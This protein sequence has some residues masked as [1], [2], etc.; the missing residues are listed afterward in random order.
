[1]VGEAQE[2]WG[3]GDQD[4]EE[5]VPEHKGFGGHVNMSRLMKAMG[6]VDKS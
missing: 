2:W 5:A 4:E 3:V 6:F 1:M